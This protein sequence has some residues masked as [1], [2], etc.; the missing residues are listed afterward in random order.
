MDGIIHN[1]NKPRLKPLNNILTKEN[2][3]MLVIVIG[4]GWEIKFEEYKQMFKL[5]PEWATQ[6]EYLAYLWKN[7]NRVNPFFIRDLQKACDEK[8]LSDNRN[9]FLK[10]KDLLSRFSRNQNRS[11]N[12]QNDYLL[13]DFE[14][15]RERIAQLPHSVSDT[16]EIRKDVEKLQSTLNG[17]IQD[18]KENNS[19]IFFENGKWHNRHHEI[20]ADPTEFLSTAEIEVFENELEQTEIQLKIFNAFRIEIDKQ[21]S[22][23][24]NIA[25]QNSSESTT[26]NSKQVKVKQK[27][28][29][30]TYLSD[31]QRKTLFDLLVKAKSIPETTNKEGFIWAFGGQN[32]I[33]SR[34]T[35]EWL[36]DKNLAVY[37]I[38]Q[39]CFDEG[40][41]LQNN[42]L[43]I[44]SKI[45][46][47]NNMAQIRNG[48]KNND[49]GVPYNSD[50]I[51]EI[52][53][54]VKGTN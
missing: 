15:L 24:K 42:Y 12:S 33:Y 48:Y 52:L 37:L 26:T 45:F 2:Y 14:K 28:Q 13:I 49:I 16:N 31:E 36:S 29:L 4:I 34:F 46:G 7:H 35:I 6:G 21:V 5:N 8:T 23:I 47:I 10:L 18:W 11:R 51:D 44:G 38:D 20:I 17:I 27:P 25:Y 19:Y 39:L 53:D 30:P 40:K 41:K 3:K 9:D 32:E 22:N 1:D 54:I 43:S 50:Q